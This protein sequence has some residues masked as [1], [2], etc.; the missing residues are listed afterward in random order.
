VAGLKL[1]SQL[2]AFQQY[3]NFQHARFWQ[4][5]PKLTRANDDRV[6]REELIRTGAPPTESQTQNQALGGKQH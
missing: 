3:F 4:L 6:G 2:L 5:K 1:L